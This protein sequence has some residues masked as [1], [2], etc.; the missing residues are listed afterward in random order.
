MPGTLTGAGVVGLP[1]AVG[2]GVGADPAVGVGV[3]AGPPPLV[4]TGLG[5]G[6]GKATGLGVGPEPATGCRDGPGP[7]PEATG[8]RVGVTDAGA[9]LVVTGVATPLVGAAV[10][11]AGAVETQLPPGPTLLPAV[12]SAH[13]WALLQ[14]R[15]CTCPALQLRAA[16]QSQVTDQRLHC[17]AAM[18]SRGLVSLSLS[19]SC[20][21]S[22]VLVRTATRQC[23][24]QTAFS[25]S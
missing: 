25:T 5:F 8:A 10:R 23:V 4:S 21:K 3:P 15:Q 7:P 2:A 12:H 6:T 19:W 22:S 11:G 18:S 1:V 14:R 9:G 13:T 17:G 20:A 16:R 24:C